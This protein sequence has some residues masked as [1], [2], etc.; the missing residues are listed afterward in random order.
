MTPPPPLEWHPAYRDHAHGPLWD[1]LNESQTP[2]SW[3][4]PLLREI[5]TEDLEAPVVTLTKQ[6]CWALAP[7]V[8]DPYVYVWRVATDTLGRSIASEAH[9]HHLPPLRVAQ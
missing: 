3:R 1:W 8:G 7:Y 4:V 9:I 5:E 2:V 6:K